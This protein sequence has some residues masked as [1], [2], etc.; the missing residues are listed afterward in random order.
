MNNFIR[1]FEK[2][3]RERVA[4]ESTILTGL[5]DQIT[6][7]KASRYLSKLLQDIKVKNRSMVNIAVVLNIKR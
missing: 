5:Q 1:E 7:D 2:L 4:M 3:S 6:N